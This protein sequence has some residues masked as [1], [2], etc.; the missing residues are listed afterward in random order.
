MNFRKNLTVGT[1]RLVISCV[2]MLAL[3]IV[4]CAALTGTFEI[5]LGLVEKAK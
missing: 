3:A 1:R 2:F 4:I 5:L